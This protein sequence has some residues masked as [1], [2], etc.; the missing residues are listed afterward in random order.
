MIQNP[1]LEINQFLQSKLNTN[2]LN[3]YNHSIKTTKNNE[4]YFSKNI[5]NRSSKRISPSLEPLKEDYFHIDNNKLKSSYNEINIEKYY[6]KNSYNHSEYVTKYSSDNFPK[7][8]ISKRDTI[9]TEISYKETPEREH[10]HY[11]KTEEKDIRRTH[12]GN[13][14]IKLKAG[15]SNRYDE[16]KNRTSYIE[17]KSML[18]IIRTSPSQPF[19]Y[20]GK[21]DVEK[22]NERNNHLN[23]KNEDKIIYVEKT[24][25][26]RNSPNIQIRQNLGRPEENAFNLSISNIHNDTENK[27]RQIKNFKSSIIVLNKSNLLNNNHIH[28]SLNNNTDNNKNAK[29]NYKCHSITVRSKNKIDKEEMRKDFK[30]NFNININKINLNKIEK[31]NKNLLNNR[32]IR[33]PIT[34]SN[35]SK[36]SNLYNNRTLGNKENENKDLTKNYQNHSL[37]ESINLK[38]LKQKNIS[39][40]TNKFCNINTFLDSVKII[41]N[42]N[43]IYSNN[44]IYCKSI[45]IKENKI[46]NK[47]P[48][49]ISK[50]AEN[51]NNINKNK[52]LYEIKIN[53]Y[54]SKDKSNK[55][56]Y[57]SD[58]CS[59][60]FEKDSKNIKRNKINFDNNNIFIERKLNNNKISYIYERNNQKI[61][62]LYEEANDFNK[63]LDKDLLNTKVKN[64]SNIVNMKQINE[65]IKKNLGNVIKKL[66]KK[67]NK[68]QKPKKIN[69]TDN[70]E[71]KD[72]KINYCNTEVINNNQ[73][74]ERKI[75]KSNSNYRFENKD[76]VN[77]KKIFKTNG[78][79]Y[80]MEICKVNN[81][82]F[83]E[84]QNLEKDKEVKKNLLNKSNNSNIIIIINNGDKKKIKRVIT[85]P[86]NPKINIK[87][88]INEKILDNSNNKSS[89]KNK[90]ISSN[91][92]STKKKVNNFKIKKSIKKN[93]NEKYALKIKKDIINSINNNHNSIDNKIQ[94]FLDIKTDDKID[95]KSQNKEEN[96]NDNQK[97]ITID[98]KVGDKNIIDNKIDIKSPNKNDN[99]NDNQKVIAINNK[100]DDKNIIDNKIVNN[101]IKSDNIINNDIINNKENTNNNIKEI[102][103]EQN[104]NQ[105]NITIEESIDKKNSDINDKTDFINNASIEINNFN[106]NDRKF[107]IDDNDH[108]ENNKN[109]PINTTNKTSNLNTS[110][111]KTISNN[112]S[113]NAPQDGSIKV[114]PE[115][116]PQD[117]IPKDTDNNKNDDG[118]YNIDNNKYLDNIINNNNNEDLKG[119]V[120]KVSIR[121]DI[122][123]RNLES[124]TESS[125]IN[126]YNNF[127]IKKENDEQISKS[128]NSS[129]EKRPDFNNNDC[130]TEEI[131]EIKPVIQHNIQR[132]RPV[133]TL[134]PSKKRSISQGKPFNLIHKYYDENFILEDDEE[135]EFKKYIKFNGDSR[136]DSKDNSRNSIN[137]KGSLCNSNKKS[138]IKLED[139][140][141][142]SNHKNNFDSKIEDNESENKAKEDKININNIDK[143]EKEKN[144]FKKIS[145]QFYSEDEDIY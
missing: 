51:G 53:I 63:L 143:K 60:V 93:N 131:Q 136:T 70:I 128:S 1:N 41:N 34:L 122:A 56:G 71:R 114:D 59:D 3:Q 24:Y 113:E 65:N 96:I 106:S 22:N 73:K 11:Y 123:S 142:K 44:N 64:D 92:S 54:E 91:E 23:Y 9:K 58:I 104:V 144:L 46:Q 40:K 102:N 76:I 35:T 36:N 66:V 27:T 13:Y 90:K 52:K 21:Y 29:D 105:N 121:K 2:N 86:K 126:R 95:N 100:V 125:L 16:K 50:E 117:S 79:E 20:K 145:E 84:N 87:K 15:S 83:S 57:D 45:G 111:T 74:K 133:F 127:L 119:D 17:E 99:I 4:P 43:N 75:K 112:D 134:P 97:V 94:N 39:E 8:I 28:N 88:L 14:K 132:K 118:N 69:I 67:N 138:F 31:L 124:K 109:E 25:N 130:L 116:F 6:S 68:N 37:F 5:F 72:Q 115:C 33:T 61:K 19:L 62:S 108:E 7:F 12:S 135:E 110:S 47:K 139:A 82:T 10:E 55:Y 26:K 89:E 120:P 48:I 103:I 137:S 80:K 81:I 141:E 129:Q 32:K 42:K 38:E 77:E 101:Q 107:L 98:N 30:K 140:E 18:N 49:R 78:K 85:T